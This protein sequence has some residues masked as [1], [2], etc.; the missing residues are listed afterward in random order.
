MATLLDVITDSVTIL[1]QLGVGQSLSPE[2][3]Q[4]GLREANRL[5]NKWSVQKLLQYWI[6]TRVYTLTANKQNYTLGPTATDFVAAR[7]VFIET[8]LAVIPTTVVEETMSVLTKTQWDAIRDKG[9]LCSSMG[10]PGS[11][12]PETAYPN[13]ILHFHPIPNYFGSPGMT[14]KLGT[15]ELIQQFASIADTINLPPAYEEMLKQNLAM[16]LAPYYDVSAAVVANLQQLAADS[17]L[18]VQK[19]NTQ[20]LTGALGVTQTL[21]EPTTGIPPPTPTQGQ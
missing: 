8:A 6:N 5:T 16:Q 18:E 1:G 12:W 4:Q 15:W 3:G 14:I 11:M 20:N 17:L 9:A 2:E 19:L 7:P 21:Q 10:T 13:M